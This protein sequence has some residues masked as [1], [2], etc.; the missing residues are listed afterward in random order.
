MDDRVYLLFE[1]LKNGLSELPDVKFCDLSPKRRDE[2]QLPALVIELI[3]LTED[4]DPGTEQLALVSH[5]SVRVVVSDDDHESKAWALVQAV[6]FWLFTHPP[7]DLDIGKVKL[8]QASLDHF[9]PNYPGHRVWL[10]EWQQPIRVGV[11][12]W[13]SQG[14]LPSELL[15]NARIN[16]KE[17]PKQ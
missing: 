11:N 17:D 14:R 12:V 8:K 13:D 6:L 3:E 7:T 16:T 1:R 5:W 9:A 4:V 2:M 10:V 15:I